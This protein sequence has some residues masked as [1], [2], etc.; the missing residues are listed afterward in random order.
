VQI[1]SADLHCPESKISALHRA[2]LKGASD[3]ATV[4]TNLMTGRPARGFVNRVMRELGPLRSDVPEFPLAT[5]RSRRSA[6]RP[7]P[8]DRASFP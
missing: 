2:A 1:G 3:D 4:V 7:K 8:P 5:G 6:P